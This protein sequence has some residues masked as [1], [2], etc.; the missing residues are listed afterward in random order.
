MYTSILRTVLGWPFWLYFVLAAAVFWASG[1]INKDSTQHEAEKVIALQQEA[2]A[3]VDLTQFTLDANR[4]PAKEVNVIGWINTDYNYNLVKRTNGIKTGERFMLVLF[5]GNEGNTSKTVRAVMVMTRAQKERFVDDPTQF[6]TGFSDKGELLMTVNGF[7]R[8]SNSFSS[9]VSDSLR[10]EGLSKSPNFIYLEPFFDGR[11]AALQ[12][13]ALPGQELYIGWLVSAALVLMGIAKFKVGRPAKS[14]AA[15][16][17]PAAASAA[18]S[19]AESEK[20]AAMDAAIARY[21]VPGAKASVA[22]PQLSNKIDDDSPIARMHRKAQA[23]KAQPLHAND[24]FADSP[25]Q[26]KDAT[27]W[28]APKHAQPPKVLGALGCIPTWAMYAA[29]ILMA[30]VAIGII[31]G[32]WAI[33]PV[34]LV[35]GVNL[36]FFLLMRSVGRAVRG[37]FSFGGSGSGGKDPFDRLAKQARGGPM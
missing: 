22:Q 31:V 35:G 37:L 24:G 7:G 2:P 32:P 11:E 30:A 20:N 5:G 3:P 25:I 34:L 16:P 12:P 13:A 28:H 6:M 14:R 10:K 8:T 18:A 4:G 33:L 29:V 21:E 19:G 36:V 9:L 23:G 26:S 27:G 15:A 17:G 1:E